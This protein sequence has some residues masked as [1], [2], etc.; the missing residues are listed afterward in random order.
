VVVVPK[1]IAAEIVE[2]ASRYLEERTLGASCS[3][4]STSRSG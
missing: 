2:A 3:A 4:S 1:R